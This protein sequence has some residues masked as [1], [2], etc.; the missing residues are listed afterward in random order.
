MIKASV[1]F[2]LSGF[3]R[4]AVQTVEI[5]IA[6][7]VRRGEQRLRVI[8]HVLINHAGR[9]FV[10]GD[11]PGRLGTFGWGRQGVARC[12]V[13]PE[14]LENGIPGGIVWVVDLSGYPGQI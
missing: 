5:R 11:S 8:H 13:A 14:S 12:G 4:G 6:N 2:I 1:V 9:N 3:Y 7:Q 10:T